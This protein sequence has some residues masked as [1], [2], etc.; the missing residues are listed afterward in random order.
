[1]KIKIFY[2]EKKGAET[3]KMDW[4]WCYAKGLGLHEI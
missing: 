1:M 4:N 3:F 2:L